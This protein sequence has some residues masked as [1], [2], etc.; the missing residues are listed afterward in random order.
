MT[1][2]ARSKM[3]DRI[4][5]R[6]KRVK[7]QREKSRKRFSYTHIIYSFLQDIEKIY[8]I[9][10][11]AVEFQSML[12]DL[13]KHLDIKMKAIDYGVQMEIMWNSAEEWTQL[14][15]TGVKIKW[16]DN[17]IKLNPGVQQEEYIDVMQFVLENP[18]T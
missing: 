5:K 11:N 7:E 18:L 14:R 3:L 1:K 17:H 13:T 4:N 6:A 9:A 10:T 2:S 16:S 15:A 8:V 12:N